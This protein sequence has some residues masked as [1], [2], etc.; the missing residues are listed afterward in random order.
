MA[1]ANDTTYGRRIVYTIKR[2]VIDA[3]ACAYEHGMCACEIRGYFCVRVRYVRIF[4][5]SDA[6]RRKGWT[7]TEKKKSIHGSK[8]SS[9]SPLYSAAVSEGLNYLILQR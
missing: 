5:C 2:H 4:V 8:T 1:A 6:R 9:R 7:A 3:Y